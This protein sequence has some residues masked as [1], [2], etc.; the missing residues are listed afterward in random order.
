MNHYYWITTLLEIWISIRDLFLN[1]VGR[2]YTI[3][4]YDNGE[5]QNIT[6]PYFLGLWDKPGIYCIHTTYNG[7]STAVIFDGNIDQVEHYIETFDVPIIANYF[8]KNF[9]IMNENEVIQTDISMID[10][11]KHYIDESN[12]NTIDNLKIILLMLF[13]VQCTHIDI[14]TMGLQFKREK[15]LV[16]DLSIQSLYQ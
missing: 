13:D 4:Y 2:L 16:S 10:H 3:Y 11:Q 15:Y 14:I 8:R 1:C 9:F 7:G 5:R 12:Y 6:V